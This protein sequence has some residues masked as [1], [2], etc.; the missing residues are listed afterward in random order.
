MMKAKEQLD[1]I[2]EKMDRILQLVDKKE[3]SINLDSTIV[4]SPISN[5]KIK[6]LPITGARIGNLSVENAKIQDSEFKRQVQKI[7]KFKHL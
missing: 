3:L 5:A 4:E 2:E 1:P 6:D 7:E